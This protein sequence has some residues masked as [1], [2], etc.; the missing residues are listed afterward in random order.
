M[1]LGR[2]DEWKGSPLYRD[3]LRL[4]RE[5]ACLSAYDDVR[6]QDAKKAIPKRWIVGFRLVSTYLGQR[7]SLL[8]RR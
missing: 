5:T 4:A 1:C 6:L 7:L 3:N 2:G 8:P